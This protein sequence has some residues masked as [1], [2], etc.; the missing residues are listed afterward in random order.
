[1]ATV[2]LNSAFEATILNRVVDPQQGGW[3]AEAA[4]AVLTLSLPAED[5]ERMNELAEKSSAGTLN[6]DEEL[7]IE[8]YIHVCRLLDLLKARARVSLSN[9][10]TP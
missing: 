7:Q 10:P 5:R 3:P 9:S 6:P 1:M 8:G 4:K 2:V